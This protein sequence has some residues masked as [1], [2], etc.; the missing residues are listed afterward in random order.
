[1]SEALE[2]VLKSCL[3]NKVFKKKSKGFIILHPVSSTAYKSEVG[4]L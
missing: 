4:F 1:M 3:N 2:D